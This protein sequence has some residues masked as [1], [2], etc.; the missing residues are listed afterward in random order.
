MQVSPV[1]RVMQSRISNV[2]NAVSLIKQ[3]ILSTPSFKRE[4]AISCRESLHAR[5]SGVSLE[6]T[7]GMSRIETGI[8][9]TLVL[10][11][12]ILCDA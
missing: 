7:V 12:D 4:I 6:V 1:A 3:H 10:L 11:T 5:I 8:S 9:L 2:I